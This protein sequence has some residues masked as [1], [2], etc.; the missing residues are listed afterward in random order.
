MG[1]NGISLEATLGLFP[2]C[3][4][5][6]TWGIYQM[7]RW[8]QLKWLFFL[9]ASYRASDSQDSTS[10]PIN[11]VQVIGTWNLSPILCLHTRGLW[12]DVGKLKR[13]TLWFQL[14]YLKVWEIWL[15]TNN[16]SG[17]EQLC[18]M[19]HRL[20]LAGGF[21]SDT[22]TARHNPCILDVMWKKWSKF[23]E[24]VI[25]VLKQCQRDSY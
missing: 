17:K 10:G 12:R 22:A 16:V 5:W 14:L 19:W 3:E 18:W 7:K 13:E 1:I 4:Y 8:F 11:N 21:P 23:R 9:G 6:Q 2:N 15:L 20:H 25:V 24:K